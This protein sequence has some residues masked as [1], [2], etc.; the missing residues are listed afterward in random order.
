MRQLP[1]CLFGANTH[2]SV[3]VQL[4]HYKPFAVP[5]D[6]AIRL[7]PNDYKKILRYF[8]VYFDLF[9]AP[10][11]SD[12]NA[13]S[14]EQ[15]LP[16]YKNLLLFEATHGSQQKTVN[17]LSKLTALCPHIPALWLDYAR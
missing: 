11:M 4:C 1:A 17:M 14:V 2:H 13:E 10:S 5:F 9:Q 3:P 15:N 7:T 8:K 6:S 16:L 12:T